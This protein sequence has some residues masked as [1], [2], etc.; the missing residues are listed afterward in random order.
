MDFLYHILNVCR[1]RADCIGC[2]LENFDECT[3]NN[4][5]EWLESEVAE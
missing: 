5:A 3:K 4:M 2:P 1:P